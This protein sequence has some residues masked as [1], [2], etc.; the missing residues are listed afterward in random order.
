MD[1]VFYYEAQRMVIASGDPDDSNRPD[2]DNLDSCQNNA[3]FCCFAQDR[4]AGD[5][6]GNCNTPYENNCIDK[7]PADN[8]NICYIDH[9]RSSDANH[10]HDG[11]TIYGDLKSG[12]EAIEGSI[13]CHGWTWGEDPLHP[14]NIYKGNLKYFVSMYDHLTQRGYARNIPGSPMCDCA[15]NVSECFCVLLPYMLI[16]IGISDHTSCC[17]FINYFLQMAVVTRADCTQIDAKEDTLM[18]FTVADGKLTTSV[19]IKDLDFDACDGGDNFA[20]NNLV[21]R[22]R[23]L[24]ELTYLSDTKKEA[25]EETLVGSAA[26]KVSRKQPLI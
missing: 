24:N 10:V 26:G 13:H 6:N 3:A 15:E 23:R 5:N 11:F 9:A 22:A 18:K 14:D 17:I 16:D 7:N 4:Q 8:S 19:K 20:N 1:D 25:I 21:G 2:F 12:N